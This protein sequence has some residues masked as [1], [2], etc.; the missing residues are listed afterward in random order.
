MSYRLLQS[1]EFAHEV[2]LHHAR[3]LDA[4]I[5]CFL[6]NETMVSLAPHY[7]NA[8]GGVQLYVHTDFFEDATRL[9][10][11]QSSHENLLEEHEDLSPSDKVASCP[12]CQST[13]I[14]YGRSMWS[15]LLFLFVF[16]LPVSL[17]N[18]K[19]HCVDC[20]NVWNQNF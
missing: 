13:N 18:N 1:Y 3:L 15:G 20:S 10:S 9:L 12:K 8:V 5:P 7:S 11:H 19:V 14:L 4:E 17:R 2:Y 6:K 16:I